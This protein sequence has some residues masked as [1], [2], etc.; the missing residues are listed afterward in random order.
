MRPCPFVVTQ[1][2]IGR[3]ERD[4]ISATDHAFEREDNE[5]SSLPSAFC[6]KI[7]SMYLRPNLGGRPH[8]NREEILSLTAE[9]TKRYEETSFG[10]H[11]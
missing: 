6:T 3:S 11:W 8:R 9:R 2:R 1:G 10:P 7:K 4:E 5:R